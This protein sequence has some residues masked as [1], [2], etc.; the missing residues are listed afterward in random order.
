MSVVMWNCH[1]WP[2]D[3]SSNVK[4]PCLTIRCQYRE[5]ISECEHFIW[6]L[7]SQCELHFKLGGGY[8]WQLIL[9]LHLKTWTHIS[10]WSLHLTSFGG[11]YLNLN[12]SSENLGLSVNF[13]WNR[14]EGWYIWQLIWVLHLKI[15]THISSWSLHL[16]SFG[17]VYLNLNTSS[18]NLGLSV[19]FIWNWGGYIWQLIWILHLKIWTCISSCS[20]HLTISGGK[21]VKS[22]FW[23]LHVFSNV[24]SPFLTTT[25][26]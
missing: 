22:P 14:G 3:I 5:C 25:C 7:G 26:Q 16:T 19:H 23:P 10:S 4:L 6:K 8:I 9:E 12:T 24:K 21:I 2:L 11:V 1:S 13:I 17:R 15:W 18:E 20:L